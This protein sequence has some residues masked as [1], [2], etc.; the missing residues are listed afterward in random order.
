MH[1]EI[2]VSRFNARLGRSIHWFATHARSLSNEADAKEL[3]DVLR[4]SLPGECKITV[5]RVETVGYE[6]SI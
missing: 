4:V 3:A 2:N 5:K 1:Y 6:L